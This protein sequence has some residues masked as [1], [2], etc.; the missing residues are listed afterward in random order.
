MSDIKEEWLG[1]GFVK[2]ET[3]ETIEIFKPIY[4]IAIGQ[5]KISSGLVSGCNVTMCG[6]MGSSWINLN[7]KHIWD[8]RNKAIEREGVENEQSD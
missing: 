6:G 7:A 4:I 3:D 1:N 5:Q 8:L 2:V